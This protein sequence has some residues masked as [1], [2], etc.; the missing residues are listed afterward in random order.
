[1]ELIKDAYFLKSFYCLGKNYNECFDCAYCRAR[2]KEDREFVKVPS[3][4]NPLFKDLPVAVNICCHVNIQIVDLSTILFMA[5][6]GGAG[7][8]PPP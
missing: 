6:C 1:M 2:G 4:I 8:E 7:A 3:E 5:H